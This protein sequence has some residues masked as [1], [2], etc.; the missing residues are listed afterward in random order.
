MPADPRAY[1]GVRPLSGAGPEPSDSG[2]SASAG[3]PIRLLVV[4]HGSTPLSHE[5]RFSGS[6]GSDPSLDAIGRAQIEALTATVIAAGPA[7]VVT[8]PLRR[9]RESAEL[10]GAALQ[11]TPE[12]QPLLRELD[13]GSWEGLTFAEAQAR[14]PEAVARWSASVEVPTGGGES[15]AMV[16]QRVDRWLGALLPTAAE[17]QT[18]LAVSHVT[19]IKCLVAAALGAPLSALF[20]MELSPGSLTEIVY[21]RQAE[22]WQPS[23]RVFNVTG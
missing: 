7:R 21:R 16:A 23:L 3:T 8:S 6:G 11:V 9:A 18:L 12:P 4:R 14:D 15:M 22:G 5:K 19:P 20:R 1:R 13:F 2:W 10:L 17:G